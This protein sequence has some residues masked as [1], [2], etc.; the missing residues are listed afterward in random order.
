MIYCKISELSRYISCSTYMKKAIE[1]IMAQDL[2]ALPFG[3]TV[4]DGEKVFIN[5]SKIE[6]KKSY[7][8]KYES[9]KKYIDIQID[10]DG[11]ESIYI[12]NGDCDCI[13]TYKEAEDYALY[14]YCE[15]DLTV[16]LNKNFC[17][18][19]FPNEIHMPCVKDKARL[20]IKC[21]IKVLD[22]KQIS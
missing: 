1:F 5:K 3:K 17:A 9:H 12:S 4:I 8:L 16:K 18:I 10:L 22:N 13:E 2:N 6:T 14:N 15:P 7:E 19:I 20:L 21:V 11:N